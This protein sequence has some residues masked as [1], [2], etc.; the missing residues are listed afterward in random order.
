MKIRRIGATYGG[1]LSLVFSMAAQTSPTLRVRPTDETATHA[2]PTAVT[3]D[4]KSAQP[5]VETKPPKA[6]EIMARVAANQDR[7]EELRKDYVY[8]QRI[9]IVTHKP[10]GRMMREET[11][12][13]EVVALPDATT[14]QLKLLTGRYWEKGKYVEFQGEMPHSNPDVDLIHR[15]EERRV[16]KECRSRR[17]AGKEK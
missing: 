3:P 8:K 13:Y 17:R 11:A 6:E 7:S 15:S 9:H 2:S 4:G 10:R 14:K 12:D 16:G 5:L 1:V